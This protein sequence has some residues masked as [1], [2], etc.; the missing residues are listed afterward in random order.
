MVHFSLKNQHISKYLRGRN[1]LRKKK[2]CN[3]RM[4]MSDKKKIVNSGIKDRNLTF[5][6]NCRIKECEWTSFYKV[7]LI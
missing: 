6:E 2:M 4:G 7:C 5:S 3:L 1:C